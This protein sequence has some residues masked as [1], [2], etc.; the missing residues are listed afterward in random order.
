MRELCWKEK[1][2]RK[3]VVSVFWGVIG[4]VLHQLY[5]NLRTS[6]LW[7]LIHRISPSKSDAGLPPVD[8]VEQLSASTF[9]L[10]GQ[11]P[12]AHTLQ[13]TN[14]YVI[15]SQTKKEAFLI[16]TGEAWSANL[17][18]PKLLQ[19]L[20]AKAI[21]SIKAILL[22]HGHADHQ[23]GV[24]AILRALRDE[25]M[26]PLP[27]V[28]KRKAEGERYPALGFDC[29]TIEDNQF[30]HLDDKL[31]LQAVYTPGHTD[32]HVAFL[33]HADG[34]IFTGDCVLGCGTAVFDDLFLYMR[35][36]VKLRCLLNESVDTLHTLYP[37]HGPVIR[38]SGLQ[39]IEDYI[40][41]RLHRESEVIAALKK[42]RW[43]SSLQLV[44]AVYGQL[45]RG[46]WLSAQA[47]LLH[48]LRKL[49]TEKQVENCFPDLWRLC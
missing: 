38:S 20:R 22:T 39:K 33:F 24:L 49:Q 44:D 17:V 1:G 25:A 40:R 5:E 35:S 10:L 26:L 13:G 19:L 30:F 11:N 2:K 34:A 36:L 41:H 15:F 27:L 14:L 31:S 37:G 46:V 28:Y 23:G 9:R 7:S 16:D 29:L 18:L 32:D 43:T 6:F 8:D 42:G 12:G 45:P 47:N 21:T 3:M 4:W 48:H